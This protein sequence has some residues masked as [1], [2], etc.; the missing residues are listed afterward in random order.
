MSSEA[1]IAFCLL[2]KKIFALGTFTFLRA[3]G[4]LLYELFCF[5][6]VFFGLFRGEHNV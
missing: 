1:Q 4:V 3:K 5:L 2:F 6:G